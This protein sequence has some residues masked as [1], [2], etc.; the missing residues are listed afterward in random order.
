MII[1]KSQDDLEWFVNDKWSSVEFEPGDKKNA[2]MDWFYEE[3]EDDVIL[4]AFSAPISGTV[5]GGSYVAIN[6]SVVHT[7]TA[8]FR[9][10]GEA[11]MFKLAWGG[12]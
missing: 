2:I 11:M 9:D 6:A 7:Y 3:C 5:L 10:V 12:S 1:V 4:A 8:W